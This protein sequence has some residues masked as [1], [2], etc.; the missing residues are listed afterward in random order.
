MEGFHFMTQKR[1]AE[2][3]LC[4]LFGRQCVKAHT[5]VSRLVL[6]RP[7]GFESFA[8]FVLLAAFNHR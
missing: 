7:A 8:S 2:V 3:S 6:R 1:R 5:Q 4:S